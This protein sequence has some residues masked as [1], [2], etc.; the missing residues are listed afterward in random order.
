MRL[1][2]F[3]QN[4][5]IRVGVVEGDKVFP[6]KE[7]AIME[8]IIHFGTHD[9]TLLPPIPLEEIR[10]APVV[11]RPT[12]IM[13]IGLNYMDHIAESKGKRPS[14]PVVF[15]K[16]PNSLQGHLAPITWRHEDTKKVDFEAELAIVIGKRCRDVPEDRAMDVIFGYTCANDVSARDLQFG[17]GQWVRGKSLDTFCPIGP[18]IVTKDEVTDPH[19]L[20]IRSTLNGHLMQSSNTSHMIFSINYLLAH[21]SRYFT[22]YPGDLLL[23][24]TPSG[25]GTFRD[26]PLYLKDGDIITVYLESIGELTNFCQVL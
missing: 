10:F 14:S 1:C 5:E 4:K 13:A 23:T 17:D 3:Y 26:P 11:T 25:V 15:A 22:L 6:L 21:L 19:N 8:D 2:Q 7:P 16:F 24:G 9:L 12:K 20:E 18:W